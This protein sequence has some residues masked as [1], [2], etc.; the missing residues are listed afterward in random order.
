MAPTTTRC[1][2]PV[3][4][5]TPH[6]LNPPKTCA[7]HRS[8]FIRPRQVCKAA[9]EWRPVFNTRTGYTMPL[10]MDALDDLIIYRARMCLGA[11]ATGTYNCVPLTED[12]ASNLPGYINP[13]LNSNLKRM[14]AVLSGKG[15]SRVPEWYC[16]DWDDNAGACT[17]PES[18]K[19]FNKRI[20][21]ERG[22]CEGS[23]CWACAAAEQTPVGGL[24][25]RPRY[26]T[27]RWH[28]W[29]YG[30][31]LSFNAEGTSAT[32][33]NPD[34]GDCEPTWTEF[35]I[36]VVAIDPTRSNCTSGATCAMG[37]LCICATSSGGGRR[38]LLFAAVP[39]EDCTC[40]PDV[41]GPPRR[42]G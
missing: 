14:I 36:Q 3:P 35:F 2:A 39:K 19:I 24:I 40:E 21:V 28:A 7:S 12:D 20:G 18:G 34:F 1:A 29:G 25:T 41:L 38:N 23:N 8:P 15:L 11:P 10:D 27:N 37:Y 13:E 17:M 5:A 26:E 16:P 6:T 22:S 4:P 33:S 30:V 32:L 9:A 42:A 31:T